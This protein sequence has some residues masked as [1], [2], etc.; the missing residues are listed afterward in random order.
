MGR[1][2][3]RSL[4][5]QIESLPKYLGML[6]LGALLL[7]VAEGAQDSA[8]IPNP[9]ISLLNQQIVRHGQLRAAGAEAMPADNYSYKC[10]PSNSITTCG[11]RFRP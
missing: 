10:A 6:A 8:T 4:Q 7:P 1:A 11:L 9:I 3:V 5:N 2:I